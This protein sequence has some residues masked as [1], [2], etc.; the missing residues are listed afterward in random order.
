LDA[1]DSQRRHLV[2]TTARGVA[3]DD[4]VSFPNDSGCLARGATA[5]AVMPDGRAI[6]F[7]TRTNGDFD[8]FGHTGRR[9][10]VACLL[11]FDARTQ[12][13]LS[14]AF[15]SQPLFASASAEVP[16]LA[17]GVYSRRLYAWRDSYFAPESVLTVTDPARGASETL[18]PL[19]KFDECAV[20]E[21]PAAAVVACVRQDL[22]ARVRTA[23]IFRVPL[24]GWPP[25]VSPPTEIALPRFDKLEAFAIAPDGSAVAYAAERRIGDGLAANDHTVGWLAID[26]AGTVP[27]TLAT[28]RYRGFAPVLDVLP[29]G[30]GVLLGESV[31]RETNGPLTGRLVQLG[32]DG[33]VRREREVPEGPRAVYATDDLGDQVWFV[34][35]G[36][37]R[38]AW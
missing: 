4:G 9:V 37:R 25:E 16:H 20:A 27:R 28:F 32:T 8:L 36:A 22:D 13:P 29:G 3:R 2:C 23:R 1:V 7:G 38:L 10:A 18:L 35:N 26:R 6:V 19:A 5:L 34:G 33:G 15:P 14:S 24:A 21:T 31:N 17:G 30:H 12:T 11:D